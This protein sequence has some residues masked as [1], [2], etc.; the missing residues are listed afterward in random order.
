V[1]G[2]NP[3]H[4]ADPVSIMEVDEVAEHTEDDD[5][6]VSI[7]IIDAAEHDAVYRHSICYNVPTHFKAFRLQTATSGRLMRFW[8]M[9][10]H[11][12]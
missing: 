9:P 3:A 1:V 4:S 8:P 6:T 7:E 12:Q 10:A 5:L 11:D 2:K